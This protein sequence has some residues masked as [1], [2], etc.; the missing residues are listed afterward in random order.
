LEEKEIVRSI[1]DPD[2]GIMN[3]PGK[4]TGLHY[5]AHA[6]LDASSGII[7]DICLTPGNVNDKE[8]YI[9]RLRIQQEKFGLSIQKVGADKG[10]DCSGVHH[11]LERMGI[12]GFIAAIDHEDDRESITFTYDEAQDIFICPAGK[13]LTF[14][15]I[16]RTNSGSRFRK[17]YAA[18]TKDCKSCP[19]RASC[20]TSSKARRMLKKPL[21]HAALERNRKRSKTDEYRM[22]QRL[23]R[24]WCEGT[25]GILKQEHNLAKT[26]KR[27]IRNVLEHC[28]F[29]ALALNLKRMVKA[30]G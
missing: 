27:G 21:H 28:L 16:D 12:Q 29:S 9:K 19:F 11:E 10:Y 3:R 26:Y 8:P 5:L 15:H 7:T 6:T 4:P 14:S 30:L 1:T 18:T 2:A 22:V 23:R 24:V 17:V 20:I 25:F 13:H